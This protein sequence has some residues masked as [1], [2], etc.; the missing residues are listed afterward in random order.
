MKLKRNLSL[1]KDIIQNIGTAIQLYVHCY[2]VV[3]KLKLSM[4]KKK[5]IDFS[6]ENS[7]KNR[8]AK[9]LGST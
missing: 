1:L 2:L 6:W 5:K 3:C 9:T 7:E 4:E 8:E